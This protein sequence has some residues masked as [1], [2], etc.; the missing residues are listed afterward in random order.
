MFLLTKQAMST[1][2]VRRAM[3]HIKPMN[4]P[5]VEIPPSTLV[6]PAGRAKGGLGAEAE[7]EEGD[8]KKKNK[9]KRKS[10]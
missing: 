9:R 7:E 10:Q 5:W 2:S 6:W 1:I 3:A 4:Q 8:L